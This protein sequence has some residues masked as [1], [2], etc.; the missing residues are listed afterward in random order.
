MARAIIATGSAGNDGTGDTLR[1]GAIKINANFAE[2]YQDVNALQLQTADSVGALSIEGISFDQYGIVFI[3]EDSTGGS[4]SPEI[5]ISGVNATLNPVLITTSTNHG[6]STGQYIRITDVVGSTELNNNNYFINV[7]SNTTFTLFSDKARTNSV[8]G[9]TLSAYTSGGIV[10]RAPN[11][12]ETILKPIEPSADN[13]ILLP[14]S[15]GTIALLTDFRYFDSS[16][17]KTL[18]RTEVIDSAKIIS[19]VAAEA[20][21]S[22][23]VAN[24]VDQAYIEARVTLGID[25]TAAIG[26]V[27]D[28]VDSSY[29]STI[30]NP[31]EF[32]DS[33]HGQYLIDSSLNNLTATLAP[34]IDQGV[35]LGTLLKKFGNIQAQTIGVDEIQ[36]AGNFT[37]EDYATD[38]ESIVFTNLRKIRFNAGTDSGAIA[39][40]HRDSYGDQFSI[41]ADVIPTIDDYRDLGDSAYRWRDLWV[42]N[43]IKLGDATITEASGI[44]DLPAGTTINGGNLLDS[45]YTI[46]LID[47]DYV[48]ARQTDIR[49]SAF[50]T[51]IVDSS[52]VEARSK[53]AAY[54]EFGDAS[55][56]TNA[57]DVVMHSTNGANPPQGKVMPRAGKVTDISA[58]LECT[59]HPGG[60]TTLTFEL[61]KNGVDTGINVSNT[62]TAISN[63]SFNSAVS[64]TFSANDRLEIK[65]TSPSGVTTDNHNVLIRIEED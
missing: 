51:D 63:V 19:I 31:N 52:Y 33:T 14:D 38:S 35:D 32:L 46:A 50:V 27:Q 10:K 3:G 64:E 16:L 28:Q 18:V 1:A 30:I 36:I 9:A 40:T 42:S 43:E 25:S 22:T 15:D 49:D 26:I 59:A 6:Y 60:N 44:I 24:I 37:I 45:T 7:I 34:K 29:I 57:S 62:I 5:S 58:R 4:P 56:L 53:H 23:A 47:S 12:W 11:A 8:D 39:F 48:Q 65:F 61:F 55:A 17:I 13:T 21:D 41:T 20:V 2:L 54:I